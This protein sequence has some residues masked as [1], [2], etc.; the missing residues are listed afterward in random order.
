MQ[1]VLRGKRLPGMVCGRHRN[2][3][4]ALQVRAE[5]EGVV[6]ADA[7]SAEWRT[8]ITVVERD[9]V[10]D[11]RGPAVHGKRGE[12]FL[13]LTWGEL[14][15]GTFT[16]FSRSKLMLDDTPAAEELAASID[17]TGERGGP[18]IARIRPP[19]VQWTAVR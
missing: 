4:V 5:P 12:R 2:V 6:R 8:E 13:Y 17:L 19:A 9:G 10:R 16:M 1:V 18:R 3:H 7:A 11:F 15:G 14:D